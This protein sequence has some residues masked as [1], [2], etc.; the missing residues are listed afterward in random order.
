MPVGV[1]AVV[2]ELGSEPWPLL[3][4][5]LLASALSL[6]P[7][8]IWIAVLFK[9]G[10]I[11]RDVL[12]VERKNRPWVYPVMMLSFALDAE[13]L[14]VHWAPFPLGRAM[15]WA[16]C[17]VCLAMLVANFVS[18]VSLHCAGNAGILTGVALAYGGWAL[19]LVWILP[20]VAW[21]RLTTGNH[22][23]G[24]VLAGSVLGALPVLLV[25]VWGFPQLV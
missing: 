18:K 15:A 13:L 16:A 19:A 22:T 7:A 25:V 4:L 12:L 8:L 5:A 2:H 6:G 10:W 11:G 24:Q 17:A 21:A 20:V 3:K 1:L 23:L 14:F 9:L